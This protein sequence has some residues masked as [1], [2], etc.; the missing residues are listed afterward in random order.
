MKIKNNNNK[1]LFPFRKQLYQ[2]TFFIVFI[3]IFF[4]ALNINETFAYFNDSAIISENSFTA[5]TLDLSTSSSD[6]GKVN[7]DATLNYSIINQGDLA[8]EYGMSV[9]VY[10]D[11]D[12]SFCNELNISI[13]KDTDN[14]Y[15]GNLT[16]LNFTKLIGGTEDNLTFIITDPGHNSV[17]KV[18]NFNFISKAWQETLD[19][20]KGFTDIAYSKV[21]VYSNNVDFSSFKG[22]VLNE[23]LPN[24]DGYQYGFDFGKD[25]S[26]MPQGEWVELY[27]NGDIDVNLTGWYLADKTPGNGNETP[28][29]T[30][31]ILVSSP[32]IP[33]HGWLVVYMNKQTYNNKG[34]TVRLFDPNNILIDSYSY[35]DAPT[36]KSYAR[37]PDGI[38]EWVDPIP[39]PGEPNILDDVLNDEIIQEEVVESILEIEPAT[40]IIN[41]EITDAENIEVVA[42]EE[43]VIE[44]ELNEIPND[45]ISQ[46]GEN[47]EE[48]IVEINAEE[49][50]IE[51][52]ITESVELNISINRDGS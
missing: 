28:I 51:D 25:N 30:D 34:D 26:H 31:H 33:A 27:N 38:G 1:N 42:L 37:I 46:S 49:I 41:T 45:E 18:C 32:I 29:N 21:V 10:D 43:P 13:S 2:L 44:E 6:L 14:L 23:F 11:S 24:P 20:S 52:I 4:S 12:I 40:E 50:V 39:T 9:E 22:I 8:F 17:G 35:E 5:K 47:I 3:L 15:T 7:L 16:G 36:N 19:Y 48:V